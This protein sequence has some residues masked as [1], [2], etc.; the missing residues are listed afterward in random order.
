MTTK[1]IDKVQIVLMG[2]N[3]RAFIGVTDNQILLAMIA[4]WVRFVELDKQKVIELNI[5]G[6]MKKS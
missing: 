6:I 4:E 3:G 5:E 1:D 2:K